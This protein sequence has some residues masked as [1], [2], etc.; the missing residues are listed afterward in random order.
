[1][2]Q[3]GSEAVEQW[4]GGGGGARHGGVEGHRVG[5]AGGGGDGDGDGDGAEMVLATVMEKGLGME[6]E[7]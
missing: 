3:W 5:A 6:L 7:M 1:M 2:G 4:G